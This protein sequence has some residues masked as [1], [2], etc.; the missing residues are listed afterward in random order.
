MNKKK[1]FL[2]IE[3]AHLQFFF[4]LD[5]DTLLFLTYSSDIYS[6]LNDLNIIIQ[7]REK[8]ILLMSDKVNAFIKKNLVFGPFAS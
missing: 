5:D 1:R 7:D 4:F 3:T 8:N 6:H 2:K